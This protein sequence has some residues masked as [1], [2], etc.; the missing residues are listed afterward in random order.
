MFVDILGRIQEWTNLVQNKLNNCKMDLEALRKELAARACEIENLRKQLADGLNVNLQYEIT[1]PQKAA[2]TQIRVEHEAIAQTTKQEPSIA[3][4]K[5]ETDDLKKD[6]A[7]LTTVQETTTTGH[8]PEVVET[9]VVEIVCTDAAIQSI[10]KDKEAMRRE[11]ELEAE[12]ARLRR[13]NQR[14]I[15]ERAEYENAIQRA[16]LRGVSSLNVEALRVLRCPPIPCCTPCAPCHTTTTESIT[17]CKR[18]VVSTRMASGCVTQR[19]G[20]GKGCVREQQAPCIVKRPCGSPCC[21]AGKSRKTTSNSSMVFL[22]HQGDAD[23][24]CVSHEAPVPR[25]CGQPV[26][27]KIEIPPCP[28][29]SR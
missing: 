6:D 25:V 26:M 18:D 8:S 9:N 24:I 20:S 15:K 17:V 1:L 10:M 23:G 21:S 4:A 3:I 22:L 5:T 7:T 13:E 28:R 29:F 2:A 16:L 14:I 11:I 27:K 19:A 12:I